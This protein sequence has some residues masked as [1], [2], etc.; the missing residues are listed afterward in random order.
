MSNPSWELCHNRVYVLPSNPFSDIPD[1]S[2]VYLSMGICT[3]WYDYQT[4]SCNLPKSKFACILLDVLSSLDGNR[5]CRSNDPDC[6]RIHK[7]YWDWAPKVGHRAR[8]TTLEDGSQKNFVQSSCI[9]SLHSIFRA[10][11]WFHGPSSG[12]GPGVELEKQ[13]PSAV[14]YV[15]VVCFVVLK[16]SVRDVCSTHNTNT[17]PNSN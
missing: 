6:C 10:C 7:L 3:L 13:T 5:I 2:T 15:C 4:L 17:K 14:G 12:P 9:C 8:D 1:R 11:G 16:D